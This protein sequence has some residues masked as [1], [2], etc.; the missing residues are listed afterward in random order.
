MIDKAFLVNYSTKNSDR[1]E[2]NLTH[3]SD[4]LTIL[5]ISFTTAL[6][7]LSRIEKK[8]TQ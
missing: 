3:Y 1:K 4:R 6:S 7:I 8:L 5:Y 2:M